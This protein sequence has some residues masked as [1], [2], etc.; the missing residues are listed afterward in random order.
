MDFDI[1]EKCIENGKDFT[2]VFENG[3]SK[4]FDGSCCTGCRINT[5]NRIFIY[6]GSDDDYTYFDVYDIAEVIEKK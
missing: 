5:V 3:E 1:I 4:T 2:V 6:F